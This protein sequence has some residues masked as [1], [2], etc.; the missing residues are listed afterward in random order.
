[1]DTIN[2]IAFIL[3]MRQAEGGSFKWNE[4][5]E[6]GPAQIV[7]DVAKDYTFAVT[8][9]RA[10]DITAKVTLQHN[11]CEVEWWNAVRCITAG[12]LSHKGD[13]VQALRHAILAWR[14]GKA[15]A[16]AVDNPTPDVS[17][18][19]D[20]VINLYEIVPT[21]V[22]VDDIPRCDPSAVDAPT[23]ADLVVD[24]DDRE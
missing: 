7:V 1:M 6:F 5:G 22:T 12:H 15:Y 10:C 11:Y 9:N 20:R 21:G 13:S 23:R 17:D 2:I 4:R 16:R 3:A 14:K 8:S 19:I 24:G 18:Y